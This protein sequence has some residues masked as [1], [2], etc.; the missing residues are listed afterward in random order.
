MESTITRANTKSLWSLY[1]RR[2]GGREGGRERREGE[3]EGGREGGR[4]RGREGGREGGKLKIV[5]QWKLIKILVTPNL[6]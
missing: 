2:E 4:E 5:Q 3:R 1:C 6:W